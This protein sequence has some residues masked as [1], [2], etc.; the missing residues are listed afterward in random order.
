MDLDLNEI[1]H[2]M[3][4]IIIGMIGHV[5]DGKSTISKALSGKKTQQFSDELE[6]GITIK[7]GYANVKIFKCGTCPSPDCYDSGPS[8]EM[9]K[10][11]K[12]CGVEMELV[13]HISLVDCP[14][15]QK[16]TS[17]MWSGTCI[18]DYTI[19]VESIT[20]P[21]I[22]APQTW[23]HMV[24]TQIA[25]IENAA[26]CLNKVDII[27][28]K[29]SSKKTITEKVNELKSFVTKFDSDKIVIPTSAVFGINMNVLCEYIA[30][31]QVKEKNL[32]V[33]PKMIGIRSF[34]INEPK[35]LTSDYKLKGGTLGGSLVQGILKVGST[36]LIYPGHT[37]HSDF[38]EEHYTDEN[39]NKIVIKVK[40]W[41]YYPIESNVLS[42]YSE[43]EKLDFAIPGGLVGVQLDIDPGL[44]R[45]DNMVGHMLVMKDSDHGINV[46]TKLLLKVTD[47]FPDIKTKK[48]K[49]LNLLG[50]E[51]I[52]VHINADEVDGTIKKY[53][54]SKKTISVFLDKPVAVCPDSKIVLSDYKTNN[55][56]ARCNIEELV[57]CELI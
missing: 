39:D 18:M 49:T 57:P 7:L 3:P 51:R 45:K 47:I 10:W 38:D 31:L 9:Q 28:S 13:V 48:E 22:P 25:G 41:K 20:N 14:G 5:A 40:N 54:D 43:T 23:E 36:V 4:T 8:S 19:L 32:T 21:T 33:F 50:G 26:V 53:K 46:T 35:K 15:H 44:T 52:K 17:T 11:C 1:M 34:D 55:I 24:A 12:I 30:N 56:M 37:Q 29:S 6:N 16:L 42:I 2:L 27:G